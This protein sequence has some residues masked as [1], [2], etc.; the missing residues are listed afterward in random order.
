MDVGMKCSACGG[1][2]C[3]SLTLNIKTESPD[4]NRWFELRGRV[5]PVGGI[6]FECACTKL[7]LG[8]CTIYETRPQVCRDL[9]PG[10]SDCLA[11]VQRRRTP[12]QYQAIRDSDDPE[13]IH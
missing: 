1:A 13:R 4:M 8:Q 11:F 9:A 12:E 3:E 6:E 10:G 2:C 7:A 5:L